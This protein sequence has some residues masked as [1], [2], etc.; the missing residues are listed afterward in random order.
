MESSMPV[1]FV[2]ST[3]PFI[4]FNKEEIEQSI[5]ARFE[6]IVEIYPERLAVQ[7]E[8]F[9]WTY[10][11]LNQQAN[12]IAHAIMAH[13]NQEVEPIVLLFDADAPALAA[14][15][16]VLKTGKFYVPLDTHIPPVRLSYILNDSGAALLL[17]DSKN[18]SLAKRVAPEKMKVVD[19]GG[20]DFRLSTENL[21]LSLSP[22][23]AS[24]ILYTSGSTGE[25]KGVIQTHRN[26]LY[27][28]MNYTN[29]YRLSPADRLSLFYSFSISSASHQI[30][31][32]LL[33]GASLFPWDVK[34]EGFSG[35]AQWLRN[36]KI[37][38]FR[39]VSTFFRQFV[40]TLA[41]D[42]KFPDLRIV[43]IGG[44]PMYR[45][46]VNL[47]KKHFPSHCTLINR[48]GSTEAGTI[49]WYFIDKDTPIEEDFVPVGYPAS[50]NKLLL[51]DELRQEV[52][53]GEIGEIV[54]KSA[55]LSPGYWRKPD[56]TQEAFFDDPAG[57]N[58]RIYLTGDLGRF[59]PDGRLVHLGR[60][61]SQVKV[62]GYRIEIGEIENALSGLESVK[63][64]VV[65]ARK[66]KE[67]KKRL[68]AYFV[69]AVDPPPT[70]S[71]LR[72]RLSQ[73]LPSYMVPSQFVLMKRFPL[74]PMGKVDRMALPAPGGKRPDLDAP[75]VAPRTNIEEVVAHIWAEI[76][77]V[78]QVGMN[79]N[80]L[81]LGGDSLLATRIFSRVLNRFQVELPIQTLLNAST[82][83]DM[84]GALAS[85]R[86]EGANGN[87]GAL[88]SAD[89]SIPLR[90]NTDP[91]P[92]SFAQER[93]WFLDQLQQLGPAYNVGRAFRL[94]GDLDKGSLEKALQSIVARHEALRTTF[95]LKDEVPVQVIETG[96]T[97][98]LEEVDLLEDQGEDIQRLIND[99]ARRPF[100]LSQDLMLR[101]KLFRLPGEEHVLH[102]TLHHIASDG[103]STGVLYRELSEF[104]A[105]YTTGRSTA[106]PELPIQ[107]ADYAV[108]QREWLVGKRLEEQLSYWKEHLA[109]SPA[110]L[111]LPADHPRPAEFT[112]Q[113]ARE[114]FEFPA[115]LL[116][117]LKKL[118][119]Q[120][121]VTLF[122][123]L[124]AA[125]QAF[126]S[127]YTGSE[128][129][130]VGSPIAGRTRIETERL[131]GFFVNTLVLRTDLSGNPTFRQLLGRV[132]D[133]AFNAYEHQDL[134]F[135]KL[136]VELQPDRSLNHSPLFQVMFVL[137]NAHSETF[138][139][140]GLQLQRLDLDTGT[141]KF[142]LTLFL[143]EEG[144]A[145]KGVLQF[146]TDLFERGTVMRL[147]GHYQTLLK[148]VVKDP[149]QPISS[150]P[151][152]AGPERDRL[153][154]EWNDT[155]KDHPNAA[156]HELFEA[157][158]EKTP[159]AVAVVFEEEVLTYSE[160]NGRA[161]QVAHHLRKRGVGP[162][163]LVGI[164]LER[165]LE[166]VIGLLGV[167]KAGG[168]YVPLDPTYPKNRLAFMI[169]DTGA[170][171]LLTQ[172][173]LLENLPGSSTYVVC[174][175]KNWES[176]ARESKE[177][178]A[179]GAAPENLAYVIYT[180]GS[181]GQPK[182]V[183]M[184]HGPLVNLIAWQSEHSE[185]GKGTRTLQYAPLGFDVSFQEIF[186]AWYA[187][188]TLV[189]INDAQRRDPV[190]TLRLIDEEKVERLFLPF[191]AL[192][193]LAEVASRVSIFPESLREVN[194][195]GEQLRITPAISHLFER[196]PHCQLVNQ[197]G[198]TEAHVVSAYELSGKP[199]SWPRLPPIGRPIANTSLYILD[200]NLEPVPIGVP[201]ELHIG[202]VGLARGYLKRSEL[203][204]D[205]FIP[206]PFTD[207]PDARLYKTGDLA[208]FLPDG[209]IEFL[210]RMDDQVKIRGFR[211]ELGEIEA[212][213]AEHPAVG[214]CVV[215]AR[216]DVPGDKRLVAYVA[217]D[218][219]KKSSVEVLR[220]FLK[221]KLPEY[222]IP[223]AF[224]MLNQFP[225]TS[226]GKVDR[227][228]LPAPDKTRPELEKAFVAPRTDVEKELERIWIEVLC[229][230][231]VGI[232]DN[233]FE[234][235][236]HSL[237][238]TQIVNRV[239]SEMVVELPLIAIFE[240]PT[241]AEI[242]KTIQSMPSS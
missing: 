98:Q 179:S 203:T 59:L 130:V 7:S 70:V 217:E 192:E 91:V 227:R 23:T 220:V 195:A 238:A 106:L 142:D 223:S 173:L 242:A 90:K 222:M 143:Q 5:P 93:L 219:Q 77:G 178:P 197:Y 156:I 95:R 25:P 33:N 22:K 226:S 47:F 68:V 155:K 164:C 35:L 205:K 107:Y 42:E 48:M 237:M 137:Q 36:K 26:V 157:Q 122:M 39:S 202:G 21:S 211:I 17:T 108:W 58:E 34:K 28:I 105:S 183:A 66:D 225:L 232:H 79:D 16:G 94:R 159:D 123:M 117:A 97:I 133:V 85:H 163:I 224:V 18:L 45:G 209:N 8:H 86:T 71:E 131:I 40:D 175:D 166:M 112:Y 216:E 60:K 141:S 239:R 138:T 128:D 234:L 2:R 124:L 41:S 32:A 83:A 167:L 9:Q 44:E 165:S 199:D 168:A 120:E 113:G 116:S 13:R 140:P 231:R 84:A 134:P 233:F 180:S 63:E 198:P 100:D 37:T 187:G 208:R 61:D 193:Q 174:L 207:M 102:L 51:L 171:V 78:E 132:S 127:R 182:G 119:Q 139:L 169:E 6:Q 43:Q 12:R 125:F 172:E 200:A 104:Y 212:V 206:D 65:L 228:A 62:A 204:A 38:V 87:N 196:L 201:G 148:E 67:N 144:K 135:E 20:L 230:E 101:A 110:L 14:L 69:P 154:V 52:H 55:Y 210:G 146:N 3:N 114:N 145:L 27:F 109:D 103:W 115:G 185:C 15:L 150:I 151:L 46:D 31:C 11:Q 177:N 72:R 10:G 191:V 147:L 96:R 121:G 89:R 158:V 152:L 75:F 153:L 88:A 149:D 56:L 24:W 241:I 221:D 181:T 19:I 240:S 218:D 30:F 57:G 92:L 118:S 190:E 229:L 99:E 74:L 136:V 215:L 161:N 235:G 1:N 111:E 194:T 54:I 76:L 214:Q 186:S 126:L 4:E 81:E 64:A 213:L 189:L 29:E 80:F 176:I 50:D 49:A 160:V 188:G 129:I 53:S 82:I 184:P 170:S 162:D 236:G 73:T